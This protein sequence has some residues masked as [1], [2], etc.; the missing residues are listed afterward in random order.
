MKVLCIGDLH[1]KTSNLPESEQLN[2]LLLEIIR[3]QRPTLVVIMGDTLHTH[4][5]IHL[6]PLCLAVEFFREV[7]ELCPVRVL[8]GNHDRRNN[9]D[10]LSPIHPFS[11]I[12]QTHRI[13][14]IAQPLVELWDKDKL[15]FVPYVP[16]GKFISAIQTCIK[17]PEELP[18]VRAVFAHQELRGVKMGT[19]TSSHGDIWPSDY[20]L[21]ISGHIHQHQ[22][23]SSNIV[24]VG[25]PRMTDF[26]DSSDKTV[27]V[28]QEW[29]EVRI[30]VGLPQKIT[31][32]SE[33]DRLAKL[34]P[35][36]RR[37]FGPGIDLRVIIRGT[38]DQIKA[39]PT[40]KL[41][42]VWKD[43]V[44]FVTRMLRE[45]DSELP[46]V[47]TAPVGFLVELTSRL[48]EFDRSHLTRILEV[49]E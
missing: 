24:Y 8:I 3:K 31:L 15:L 10:Y 17:V 41:Y 49:T 23:L 28:F 4:S 34:E 5:K 19:I 33:Y 38:P 14:V 11:S 9:S 16:P 25:T 6:D 45:L 7:S 27:S 2:R 18:D 39:L 40:N 20:P 37:L 21:L 32:E 44:K 42:L 1:Y 22:R 36:L 43:R 35:D 46:E 26:G 47:V 12:E 13:R 29:E 30:P 48:D